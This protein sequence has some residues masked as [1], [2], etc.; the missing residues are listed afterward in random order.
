MWVIM[1][2]YQIWD[3]FC[4]VTC[5]GCKTVSN[6]NALCY[7][8]EEKCVAHN[9]MQTF[10]LEEILQAYTDVLVYFCRV[11]EPVV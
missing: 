8:Y 5:E 2:I 3:L 1:V 11:I 9:D 7:C 10:L 6:C 4:F